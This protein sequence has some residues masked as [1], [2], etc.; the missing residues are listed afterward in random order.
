VTSSK[1]PPYI[2]YSVE[3]RNNIFLREAINALRALAQARRG[4]EGSVEKE[5]VGVP[6]FWKAETTFD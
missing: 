4:V 6:W 3:Y 1:K 5:K 2:A